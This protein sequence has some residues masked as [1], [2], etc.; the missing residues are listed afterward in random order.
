MVETDI[1]LM[2]ENSS[3]QTVSASKSKVNSLKK[4]PKNR[5]Q[6]LI[7]ADKYAARSA[8]LS[9]LV[10][11][12][13][14]VLQVSPK[15]FSLPQNGL[16][17]SLLAVGGKSGEVSLWRVPVPDHYSIELSGVPTTAMIVGLLHA[18]ASWVTAISWVLLDSKSP[19]PQVLLA[20]GSFD[21]R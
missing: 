4:I 16:A 20:T 14:P 8:M 17:I 13:S 2:K 15:I 7:S 9:S 18:H 1:G 3:R 5:T 21:G 10:V 12:W 6:P 11:A 19:N